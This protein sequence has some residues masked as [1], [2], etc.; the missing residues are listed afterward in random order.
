MGHIDQLY[1]TLLRVPL[2]V[3]MPGVPP[4]GSVMEQVSLV[5]L[6]PTALSLLGVAHAGGTDGV[7]LR[8]PLLRQPFR[9][10]RA[11]VGMTYRP[12]AR[13]ELRG[14]ILDGFK[15]IRAEDSGAVEIYDLRSDPGEDHDLTALWG[16]GDE[17]RTHLV[18]TLEGMLG[19][20]A[21]T[22][23]APAPLSDADRSM[24]EALG[25]VSE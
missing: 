15:L 13:A 16:V 4:G 25:Y 14:V 5:D 11:H 20:G 1:D 24:L 3:W 21:D 12:L 7:D 8:P 18:H 22:T 19:P 2:L 6:F 23:P 17:R 9:S 10:N